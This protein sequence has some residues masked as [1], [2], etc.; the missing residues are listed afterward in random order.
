MGS[1]TNKVENC[2]VCSVYCDVYAIILWCI[3]V[4]FVMYVYS[5]SFNVYTCTISCD[6]YS[7]SCDVFSITKL[8][9]MGGIYYK[10]GGKFINPFYFIKL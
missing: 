9:C 8:Y 7:I 3:F 2:Y 6:V 1:I 5:I 10:Q 4:N